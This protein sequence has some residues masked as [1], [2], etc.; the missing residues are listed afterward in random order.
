LD[1]QRPY[2]NFRNAMTAGSATARADRATS[3]AADEAMKL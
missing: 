1:G 2:V 3:R